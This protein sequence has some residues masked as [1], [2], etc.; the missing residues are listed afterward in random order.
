M[1]QFDFVTGAPEKYMPMVQEL[2]LIPGRVESVLSG[3]AARALRRAD[4]GEW[5]AGRVLS[6]MICYARHN[7]DFIRLIAWMTNPERQPWDE[8]TEVTT[9]GLTTKS[10]AA[11]L[12]SLSSAIAETTE[13]LSHTPDAQWGRPGTVPNFGLRS[14]RQQLRA[15]ID[16]LGDHITQLEAQLAAPNPPPSPPSNPNRPAVRLPT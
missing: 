8:E 2:T 1:A 14:L 16:H 7:G 5:S 13:L 10:G 6:H 4:E 11:L 15:H 12:E 9:E 3:H